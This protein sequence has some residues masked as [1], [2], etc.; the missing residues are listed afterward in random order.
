M[1][2]L[3]RSSGTSRTGR[4]ARRWG[5]SHSSGRRRGS[6]PWRSCRCRASPRTGRRGGPSRVPRRGA[7]CARP[8][9]ARRHRR[10]SEGGAGDRGTERRPRR[11]V[12]PRM[13]PAQVA[14]PAVAGT[15]KR[16]VPRA[17]V[18]QR[19][20]ETLTRRGA[21]KSQGRAKMGVPRARVGQAICEHLTHSGPGTLA[22]WGPATFAIVAGAAL[23]WVMAGVGF[24]NYDTL[25]GLVWGQQLSRAE[26][27]RVRAPDR[28]D[29]PSAGG[30]A[31]HTAGPARRE[32]G[33]HDRGGAR[34]PVAGGLRLGDLPARERLVRARGGSRRGDRPVDPRA[35]ALLRGE[36]LRGHP[37]HAL[38]ALAPC[39]SRADV[40]A[41]ERRC[42]YCSAWPGSCG[43]RHGPFLE[44]IG[45]YWSSR[46]LTRTQGAHAGSSP[47]SGC[48]RPRHPPSGW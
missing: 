10:T 15:I 43:Q 8:G 42:S 14:C 3:P 25:Y 27:A 35:G 9:P 5:R 17:R 41:P 36:G 44:F 34:L 21:A 40:A 11:P 48:W 30:D 19:I 39:S 31:R 18:G 12:Y 37:L 24:V 16:G 13:R 29:A 45:S 26:I 7:G 20:R 23:L 28:A 47:A 32:R 22:R 1:T 38:R 46:P 4:T 33:H 6:S 2:W